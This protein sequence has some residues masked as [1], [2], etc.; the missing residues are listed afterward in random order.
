MSKQG[1]EKLILGLIV[2]VLAGVTSFI[3]TRATI[4]NTKADITWVQEQDEK[5]R[6]EFKQEN[7]DLKEDILRA[8]DKQ[9]EYLEKLVN[10]KTD[11]R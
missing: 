2:T 9:N 5:L 4:V 1:I 10:A 11:K 6:Q 8:I 3:F 7:K